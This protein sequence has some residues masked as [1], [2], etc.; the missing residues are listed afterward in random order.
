LFFLGALWAQKFIFGGSDSWTAVISLFIDMTKNIV[1]HTVNVLQT[2][3]TR[4]S[5]LNNVGLLLL[6]GREGLL[7]AGELS[8]QSFV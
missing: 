3:T 4:N 7:V 1:F 6:A 2:K 8:Q 5:L